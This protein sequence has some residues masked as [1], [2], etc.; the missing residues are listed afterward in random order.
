M[1]IFSNCFLITFILDAFM[2]FG[3]IFCLF[4]SGIKAKEL[5]SKQVAMESQQISIDPI[6]STTY[7]VSV[8]DFQITSALELTENR[9]CKVFFKRIK[10]T[11]LEPTFYTSN[12][13]IPIRFSRPP[14][15][16]L[17]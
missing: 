11:L 3:F 16:A 15:T 7:T 10:N 12:G 17:A 8:V 4:T 2:V 13:L 1:L 14:P 9:P 5:I 6:Q